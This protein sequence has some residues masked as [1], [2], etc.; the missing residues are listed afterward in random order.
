VA[1]AAHRLNALAL[2][3]VLNVWVWGL[4]MLLMDRRYTSVERPLAPRYEAF[5]YGEIRIGV[6]A[7][8]PP[9]AVAGDD[10]LWG[11]DIDLARA[12][13]AEIG[14]PVRF[15]NMG[16]DGLYDSIR[17]DQVDAVIS[18]LR[19]DPMRLSQ[20]RYTDAYFDNGLVLVTDGT[21]DIMT[22]RDLPGHSLAFEF[23]SAAD[24]EARLWLRRVDAFEVRPYE[25]PAYAL[26]AVRL[27]QADA[28]LVD[29]VTFGLYQREHPQWA[30]QTHHVTQALYAVAVRS[31]RVEAWHSLNRALAT[32]RE[33]GLLQQIIERWL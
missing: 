30:A 32:I 26:D 18:A 28:A 24:N 16:F 13:A 2:L 15:V 6:D 31:D 19:V 8:Y 21:H 1:T 5:P 9:F 14:L 12:L 7:S 29:A 23:G 4:F 17:A 27:N 25:L 11:L 33:T 10:G 3:V 22:M 20:V